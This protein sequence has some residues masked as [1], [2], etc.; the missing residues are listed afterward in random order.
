[1]ALAELLAKLAQLLDGDGKLPAESVPFDP[2]GLTV[3]TEDNVQGA[4]EELDAA[5]PGG[6]AGYD[7]GTSFPGSPST[8]DKF[9]RTD[10]NLLFYYDGTRWLTT[11]LFSL[12]MSDIAPTTQL[13]ANAIVSLGPVPFLGTYSLWLDHV[14]FGIEHVAGTYDGSNHWNLALN[15][16]TSASSR[17]A[18]VAGSDAAVAASTVATVPVAVGAVLNAAACVLEYL[19]SK[20]GSP[21]NLLAYG[22]V[23]F[24][25]VI[26]T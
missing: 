4:L 8:S 1:M 9:Y 5:G 10:L 3:I 26:A 2:T 13:S 23:L 22:L 11:D 12:S 16:Y 20:T 14:D 21:G 19:P 24:Y 15:Y 6:G 17:V 18:I 7:E 25:R